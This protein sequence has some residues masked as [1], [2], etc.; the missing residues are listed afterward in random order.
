MSNDVGKISARQALI[1]VVILFSAPAIRYIPL[2][3]SQ[4]AK[5]AA[6]LSPFIA[7]IFEVIY[8]FIWAK[9]IQ[10]F[11]GKSFVEIVKDIVGKYIGYFIAALYFLWITFLLAYNVRMYVERIAG[12]AMNMVSIFVILASMLLLVGYVVRKGIVTLAKMGELFF[13]GLAL[14]F[15]IYN[16]MVLPKLDINNLFP[17]TYKD[18]GPIFFAN[19]GILAIFA[20][21]ILVFVFNDKIDYRNEFKKMSIKTIV[22]L[23]VITLSVIIIPLA[24][25]NWELIVK[26]PVP[27]L[28]SM[29]QISLFNIIERV[30]SGIIMFWII[31]DFTLIAIFVYSGMHVLR[32]SL[33]LSNVRPLMVIYLIGIFFISLSLSKN[34]MELKILSE[35]FLTLFNIIM[36]YCIPIII[37]IIGKIR[38]KV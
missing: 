2:Y 7:V 11:A 3:T 30:E 26:M 15:I 28:N 22:V 23:F 5:Q 34:T 12:A 8:M 19:F 32:V 24:A 31:S 29:M 37:F 20:Y 13:M 17:I 14:I 33:K 21:N 35:R 38:K 16:V 4:Q 6:W 18:I 36:G 10:K 25:F 9:I 27:Y 1:F